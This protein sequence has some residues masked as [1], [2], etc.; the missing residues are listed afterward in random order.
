[1]GEGWGDFMS[2]VVR[3]KP[4]D[5]RNTSYPMSPWPT[6][7]PDGI[8][9]YPY[10]TRLEIN[11]LN[12][13]SLNDMGAVHQIGT[14]WATMLNEVLWNL[15]DEHGQNSDSKPTLIDDVPTDGRYLAMKLVLD[16]MAL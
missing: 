3:L 4:E 10:S 2:I 1:M 16:A 14:V 8:R 15:I 6:D 9:L 5:H 7:K 13:T 11:P 12:Y